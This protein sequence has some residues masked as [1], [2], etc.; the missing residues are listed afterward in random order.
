MPHVADGGDFWCDDPTRDQWAVVYP[1]WPEM[2]QAVLAGRKVVELRVVCPRRRVRRLLMYE[3]APTKKVVGEAFVL[4]VERMHRADVGPLT[5]ERACATREQVNALL[6]EREHIYA[7]SLLHP[8][9]YPKPVTWDF[10][11]GM[12]YVSSDDLHKI[13]VRGG[14][15]PVTA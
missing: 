2:S 11:R 12:R 13:R 9:T 3:N 6:G 15:L 8:R 10:V 7:M 14:L 5:L 1:F 4:K